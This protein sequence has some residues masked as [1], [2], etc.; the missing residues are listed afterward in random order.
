[1][2]HEVGPVGRRVDLN[3]MVVF[4]AVYRT[5]NLTAAG[6][7]LGLSQ[8]AIS[9]A[10][11]RLRHTFKDPLF[12]RAPRGVLPTPLSDQIA[13]MVAEG[14]S[15]IRASFE[16]QRFD[17][18]SSSRLFTIAMGDIG[19]VVQLPLLMEALGHAPH[20]HLRTVAIPPTQAR[21]ALGEGH[22]DLAVSNFAV[23]PPLHEALLGKPGYATIVRRNHPAIRSKLTLAAFR[24][25]RHLLVR[26]TDA[27]VKHGEVIEK[28]LRSLQVSIAMQVGHFFPVGAIVARSDLV[29]TVPWGIAKAVELMV[30]LRLFK[31]PIALPPTH[32]SLIWHER[33]HRDPG[34]IWLREIFLR[35]TRA[36]Y[37]Q[38]PA[39]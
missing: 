11:S 37:A 17:P 28:A 16:P 22:I 14:L 23:R 38:F 21:A 5:R 24:N 9:H 32:L 6:G 35:V 7:R 34:N 10:L 19:E 18:V 39:A 8:P 27:G 12:V 2:K 31:P 15:V 30:P 13:P 1:M 25:A 29:A 36:L 26:P 33:Y 3:L 20:V 4:E